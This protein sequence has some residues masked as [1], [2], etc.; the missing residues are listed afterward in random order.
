[1]AMGVPRR[2]ISAIWG[3]PTGRRWS[4]D[5]GVRGAADMLGSCLCSSTGLEGWGLQAGDQGADLVVDGDDRVL[6]V[7]VD[8]GGLVVLEVLRAV[9]RVGDHDDLVAA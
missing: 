5:V 3:R 1:M 9:R 7:D 2:F 6:G 8:D 4:T